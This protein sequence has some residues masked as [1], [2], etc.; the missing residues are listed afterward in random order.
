MNKVL[1]MRSLGSYLACPGMNTTTDPIRIL[2]VDEH[3]S[4]I[5]GLTMVIE[6]KPEEM[7]VVATATNGKNALGEA[8]RV[9][10]DLIVLEINLDGENCLELL[11]KLVGNPGARVLILTSTRDPVIHDKAIMAG[12]RGIV[13]KSESAKT[14]LKAIEK[15]NDGEIWLSKSELSR[16]F[17]R[18]S[19]KT[20]DEGLDKWD[21]EKINSLTGRERQI[22]HAIVKYDSSTNREIASYIYISESTLKNH[23]STIYNKLELRNRIDLLKFAHA[24]KLA[25]LDTL[26]EIS[27]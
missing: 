8:A 27:Q 23:L 20:D 22:I 26:I 13:L 7:K 14:V 11:P 15:V 17:D 3:T 6:T 18:L 25:E 2:L 5:D 10:P 21:Q 19:N 16:V 1:L 12:A 24:H 9:N 4:F